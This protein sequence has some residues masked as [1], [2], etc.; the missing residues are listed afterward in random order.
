MS[1]V[2]RERD[3]K[4][5]I[6][7][8]NDPASLNAMTPELLG[9]LA[10]AVGEM[11]ID[12]GIRALVL[13][14]EGRGFC[15]GQNLKAFN[16][17]GDN[18]YTGVMTHYW[19]A[20]QALRECRMPVVVAVNG[21][22]AGGGFS[23]AMSGD[24]ILAARSASFIQ[25]FSRIGLV[26]DLGSTWLLP[27][28]V[29]RQ[30]ALELM[31]LNEPLSAERAREWGLV[32][33]VVDDAKLLDEAKALA[34]RLADGPTRALVATRQL[35]EASEHASYA[36]QFRREIELQQV[37]RESADAKEGRQAFVEKRKAQFTGR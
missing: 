21:V 30:R 12:P 3:G 16:S 11:S 6:L 1:S 25:V 17:L 10:R 13:T 27:R 2:K 14:G 34:G 37:I 23:L 33:D 28:L 7:T 18:I 32:R 19:P 4:V 31:L 29:G 22:A 8:L 15:S 35:L 20:M 24:M 26:P 5:G 36:E 9:D